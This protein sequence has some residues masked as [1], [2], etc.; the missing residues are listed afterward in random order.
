MSWI[1]AG[2]STEGSRM[3]TGGGKGMEV[4]QNRKRTRIGAGR[5][6]GED[7]GSVPGGS[8]PQEQPVTFEELSDITTKFMNQQKLAYKNTKALLDQAEKVK[9]A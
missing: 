7:A 2:Q 1:G 3:G 4:D 6:G 8:G 9:D 5:V